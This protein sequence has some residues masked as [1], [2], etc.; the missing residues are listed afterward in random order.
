MVNNNI[1]E[2]CDITI[3]RAHAADVMLVCLEKRL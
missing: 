3:G 1:E 2:K